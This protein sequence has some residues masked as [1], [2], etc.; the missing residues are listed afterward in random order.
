MHIHQWDHSRRRN[1]RREDSD[2]PE[3][4]MTPPG[5]WLGKALVGDTL[6]LAGAVHVG[7]CKSRGR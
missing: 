7:P 5:D 4:G 6:M 1:L 2:L 3:P